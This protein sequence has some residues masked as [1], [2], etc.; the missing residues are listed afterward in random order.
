M[1]WYGMAC[2]GMGWYLMVWDGWGM[3]WDGK[4]WYGMVG[5][6]SGDGMG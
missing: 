2:D 5:G 1:R 6:W 4:G 3:E